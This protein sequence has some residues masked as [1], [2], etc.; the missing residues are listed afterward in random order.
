MLY[1]ANQIK[2]IYPAEQ[3][4]QQQQEREP[5]ERD[6]KKKGGVQTSKPRLLKN[7]L[8][9]I[10]NRTRRGEAKQANRSTADEY[11]LE[12][13]S[14]IG[15]TEWAREGA[16]VRVRERGCAYNKQLPIICFIISLCQ[17]TSQYAN[18]FNRVTRS[19]LNCSLP[20]CHPSALSLC[21]RCLLGALPNS[22]LS[23]FLLDCQQQSDN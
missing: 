16:S 18:P 14:N 22:F 8:Q 20:D 4:Q 5:F 2:G 7:I 1:T 3:E 17:K 15:D 13:N 19:S 11:Q 21:Q 12:I 6:P 10:Q 23:P 9:Q